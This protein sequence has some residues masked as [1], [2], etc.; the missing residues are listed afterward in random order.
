MGF[1]RYHYAAALCLCIGVTLGSSGAGAVDAALT[2]AWVQS[3]T[4]CEE[5]F[6]RTGK[7]ATFKKPV[8]AFAPAFIISGNRIRTPMASCQIKGAKP[9]GDRRILRLACATT[10]SVDDIT[11]IFGRSGDGSLQRYL[12]GQD[13]TGTSYRR[14]TF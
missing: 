12:N 4:E 3:G 1:A 14:C 11:A 8:S 2:G 6:A 5:V 7:G 13:E 9:S 10:V